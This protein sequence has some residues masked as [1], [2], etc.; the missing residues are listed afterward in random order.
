MW[1]CPSLNLGSLSRGS[2]AT[3]KRKMLE[4]VDQEQP[5]ARYLALHVKYDYGEV[6]AR[7]RVILTVDVSHRQ[8]EIRCY[9]PADQT[10]GSAVREHMPRRTTMNS[11]AAS[12]STSN[13]RQRAG[14]LRWKELGLCFPTSKCSPKDE[15]NSI[16]SYLFKPIVENW[17]E[18]RLIEIGRDTHCTWHF[19][20]I[21][22]RSR[23]CSDRD[24]P[25]TRIRRAG[26][27]AL[28]LQC[29]GWWDC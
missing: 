24:L 8:W 10:C 18:N 1:S 17:R 7:N 14:G 20:Q 13:F 15:H 25:P 26:Q 21:R 23:R 4:R 6:L 27:M 16:A 3:R 5:V 28:R 19:Y 11:G 2:S 12:F 22:L 9:T 29:S